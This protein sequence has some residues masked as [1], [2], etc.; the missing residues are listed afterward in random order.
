VGIQ[1]LKRLHPGDR[2]G[3]QLEG[4]GHQ[5]SFKNFDPKLVLSK[6]K[7]GTIMEQT[8]RIIKQ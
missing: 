3:P 6:R 4:W 1:N 8:E 5:P 7:A 2:Q